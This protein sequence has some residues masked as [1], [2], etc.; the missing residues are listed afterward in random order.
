MSEFQREDRYIVIKRSDLKKVPVAYRSHL[1]DPMFALL[2]HL[3]QRRFAVIESDW[4]EFEPVWRMIEARVT[5]V[6]V[7]GPQYL[8]VR[9]G[10]LQECSPQDRQYVSS[11]DYDA[12]AAQRDEGLAREAEIEREN[13]L[14]RHHCASFLET[15]AK[16]CDLLGIDPES[17]QNAQ[18]KPSDVLYEHAKDLQQRLA[19]AKR[20]LLD[21]RG[22]LC[23]PDQRA[24][25]AFL[26][27]S[28]CADGEQPS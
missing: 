23:G 16:T 4:P 14:L 13:R 17:A 3:P 22:Q 1:V 20:L 10:L 7:P 9:Y 6:P 19:E 12:L 24:I 18:G 27:S 5:G 25:D 26:A 2:A 11:G 28:G 21:V 8:C 15:M